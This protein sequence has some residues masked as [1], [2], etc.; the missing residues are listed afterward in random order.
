MNCKER[1]VHIIKTGRC[2]ECN[3]ENILPDELVEYADPDHK[4]RKE[5]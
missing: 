5:L 4:I 2:E 3:N 1:L